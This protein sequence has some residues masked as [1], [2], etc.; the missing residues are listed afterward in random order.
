MKKKR[1]IIL[2]F[3]IA[4]FLVIVAISLV[5]Y[6]QRSSPSSRWSWTE[7]GKYYGDT[8][9]IDLQSLQTHDIKRYFWE[10]RD[11]EN[12]LLPMDEW[13]TFFE[14]VYGKR[15]DAKYSMKRFIEADCKR[16]R[17]RVLSV[18]FY[19]T[20]MAE[21]NPDYTDNNPTNRW[22]VSGKKKSNKTDREVINYVCNR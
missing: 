11:F 17:H 3:P 13:G 2:G 20:R 5:L 7:V 18:S 14:L 10:M 15:K 19:R 21:G 12:G 22:F 9:Y 6:N 1:L 4:L 8:I 16:F